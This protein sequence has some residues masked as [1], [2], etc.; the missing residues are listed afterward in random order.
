MPATPRSS[1][2]ARAG[3]AA[4]VLLGHT[5]DDQAE[6]VLLGLARGSGARSL[7]GMPARRG[8]FA[9][10]FLA[11][12]RAVTRAACAALGLTPARG[13]VEPRPGLRAGAACAPP[14]SV[15]E[16]AARPRSRAGAGPHRR[17]ARART[18]RRSRRLRSS[19]PNGRAGP[20]ATP[21][22]RWRRRPTPPPRGVTPARRW[23]RRPT[24]SAA[25]GVMP[26]RRWR[27]RPTRSAAVPCSPPPARPGAPRCPGLAARA[28]AGRARRAVARAG[29]RASAGRGRR[30]AAVWHSWF[31]AP[32]P[33]RTT[34]PE[35]PVE[36]RE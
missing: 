22:R 31:A 34:A 7:A 12:P 20:A 6:T 1:A 10:P 21:A 28:G 4:L 36:Q 25:V 8:V 19:S 24:P 26:A 18:R 17:A 35:H 23:R 5:L 33:S 14:W 30:R 16:A 2:A 3:G 9:R 15:L 27:R 13:P 32:G 29:R 11:V